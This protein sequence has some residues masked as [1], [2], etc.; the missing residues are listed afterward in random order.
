M[1]THKSYIIMYI[2][3]N[4]RRAIRKN[5]RQ[6]YGSESFK[7]RQFLTQGPIC[8]KKAYKVVKNLIWG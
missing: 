8:E 2:Q 3:K 5:S 7:T 4:N 1:F 6:K